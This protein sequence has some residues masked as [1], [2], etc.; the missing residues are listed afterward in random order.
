MRFVRCLDWKRDVVAEERL[1]V[2]MIVD[3]KV[4]MVRLHSHQRLA[5]KQVSV[6]FLRSTF[7]QPGP[8]LLVVREIPTT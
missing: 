8:I 5:S 2:A 7:N 6:S 4:K 1:M 3:F